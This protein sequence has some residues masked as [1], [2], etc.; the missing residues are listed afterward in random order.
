[1]SS[2]S[3]VFFLV[4]PRSVTCL[5]VLLFL[6][7]SSYCLGHCSF[8][9]WYSRSGNW[10]CTKGFLLIVCTVM[11]QNYHEGKNCKIKLYIREGYLLEGCIRRRRMPKRHAKYGL[12]LL[13]RDSLVVWATMMGHECFMITIYVYGIHYWRI[14][15]SNYRSSLVAFWCYAA[16]RSYRRHF[17]LPIQINVIGIIFTIS[18]THVVIKCW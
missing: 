3:E 8:S 14:L 6:F 9:P 10:N 13:S 7:M 11:L 5:V 1:M 15:I 17:I 16:I 12:F 2:P 4:P 18:T